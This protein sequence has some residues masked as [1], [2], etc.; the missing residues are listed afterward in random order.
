MAG[1]G[2]QTGPGADV[3]PDH[4]RVLQAEGIGQPDD[5]L[6]H[7]RRRQQVVPALGMPVSRQVDRHQMRVLRELIPDAVEGE[8]AFRPRAQQ[9][10]VRLTGLALRVPD[11]QTVD[12]PKLRADGAFRSTG[13]DG[14]VNHACPAE[15]RAV[16][17]F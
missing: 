12:F 2:E 4:V 7:R 1:R 15:L 9:Q 13:R 16:S 6:A 5:E 14:H 10:R 8:Q 17:E 11:L 3:G